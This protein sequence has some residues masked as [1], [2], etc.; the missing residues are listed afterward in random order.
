[1]RL[2]IFDVKKSL[3]LI[4]ASAR[5]GLRWAKEHVY[6]WLILGPVVVGISYFTAWRLAG[7]LPEWDLSPGLTVTAAALFEKERE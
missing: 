2:G 7:N 3:L 1:L 6:S 5:A 4:R